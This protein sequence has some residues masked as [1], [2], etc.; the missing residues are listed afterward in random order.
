MKC[1]SERAGE[2]PDVLLVHGWGL[3]SAVWADFAAELERIARVTR[4]DLPG[5]GRSEV[6]AS[7]TLEDLADAL[8]GVCEKPVVAIGWSLGALAVLVLA[9]RHPSRLRGMVLIGATPRFVIGPD[10]AC[11]VPVALLHRFALDLERDYGETLSRFLTLQLGIGT[12]ERALLQRLRALALMKAAPSS[13]G[14][15]A[16]LKLLERTDVRPLLPA[17]MTPALIIHGAR[18]KLAPIAA[19]RYLAA[20]LPKA[21]LC[22]ITDAGHAPFLSHAALCLNQVKTV[23]DD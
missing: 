12:K 4:V 20:T 11:A 1:H 6:S 8:A 16:G 15:R 22:E 21:R 9:Q 17:L 13:D 19:G 5:H 18:D 10:W 23:I 14:L 7:Y 2:G 3:H